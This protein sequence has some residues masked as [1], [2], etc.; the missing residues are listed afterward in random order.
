M[1]KSRA[2]EASNYLSSPQ[3]FSG[4]LCEIF[5]ILWKF[6]LKFLWQKNFGNEQVK[7]GICLHKTYLIFK[8]VFVED[9][10]SR[11]REDS[12]REAWKLVKYI[13]RMS[14]IGSEKNL[15]PRADG[16]MGLVG[17]EKAEHLNFLFCSYHRGGSSDPKGLTNTVK[18]ELTH[19]WNSVQRK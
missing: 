17:R 7:D 19:S 12:S 1:T 13:T 8:L 2:R 3:A 5:V 10:I 4:N 16:V 6:L 14:F 18:R 9:K 15:P 11:T